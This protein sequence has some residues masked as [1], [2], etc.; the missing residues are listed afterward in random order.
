MPIRSAGITFN[1]T[2]EFA[3]W[4]VPTGVTSIRAQLTGGSGSQTSRGAKVIATLDV[5]PGEALTIY[6]AGWAE[7]AADSELTLKEGGWPYGGWAYGGA[8]PGGGFSAIVSDG[9][10]GLGGEILALAGGGGGRASTPM[11]RDG[12]HGGGL[13]G[14]DG[15]SDGSVLGGGGGTE[16]TPGAGG[17]GGSGS[18]YYPADPGMFCTGGSGGYTP[19]DL[20]A[21]G[22][23][24]AG[25][26]G[27]GG[28]G[29]VAGGASAGG[30]GGSSYTHPS[31]S[32]DVT[33]QEGE[34]AGGLFGK[35]ELLWGDPQPTTL[36]AT[37]D[38]QTYLE[39]NYITDGSDLIVTS[40]RL[41]S[42]TFRFVINVGRDILTTPIP[43]IAVNT[44]LH[45]SLDAL[46]SS[47]GISAVSPED[48]WWD[49]W[50]STCFQYLDFEV[51]NIDSPPAGPSMTYADFAFTTPDG[52]DISLGS[53]YT[54]D[55][56]IT[57]IDL[58]EIFLLAT[59]VYAIDS[60]AIYWGAP[61]STFYT[62]I[63]PVE[64]I[65]E[66]YT[67]TWHDPG[68]K[69]FETGIDRGALYLLDGRVIP[70]NGLVSVNE[71]LGQETSPV[72]FDGVKLSEI[73]SSSGF[74]ASVSA[75]T[76]PDELDELCG[77]LSIRR[78]VHLWD[79]PSQSFGFTYRTIVGNDLDG[80]DA[81]HKIHF[82]YNI[83]AAMSD[84]TYTTISDDV[85]LTEFEWEFVAVPEQVD[86]YRPSTHL[87]MD[88]TKA[89]PELVEIIQ[90]YIWGT[91]SSPPVLP[92]L[93]VLVALILGQNNFIN[94]VDNG[95]GTWTAS[96][97]AVGYINDL[98][99]GVFEIQE[100]N[101]SPVS[102]T[103]YIISPTPDA[104]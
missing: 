91:P 52:E 38:L 83:S 80:V 6:V 50:I 94:I 74:S 87:V 101:I 93:N 4:V 43:G 82:V 79:Q 71:N 68:T 66:P 34:G 41:S 30:G 35:V 88:T 86:A 61:S 42:D 72:F 64:P 20:R 62:L 12:G 28:G 84:R 104:P 97:D 46:S 33:Y 76:Y 65:L 45:F 10:I 100:A 60:S 23:G 29:A 49:E 48:V 77:G 18:G 53:V 5:T 99:G 89:S 16:T 98:G 44:G 3:T 92:P 47:N 54:I 27:G 11:F 14:Q 32:S 40:Q 13:T 19:G 73:Q 90:N 1:Y 15:V 36:T 24:G 67:L 75:I 25:Y 39:Y 58:C 70:W 95:D 57:S 55:V 102:L 96:T 51:V 31:R 9:E 78:G 21:G 8:S 85:E 26:W 7:I 103:E 81:G 37:N 56:R 59:S 2:G 63:N 22:G 17:T 69:V